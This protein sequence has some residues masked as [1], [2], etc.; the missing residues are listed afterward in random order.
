MGF[1]SFFLG[2]VKS[3]VLGAFSLILLIGLSLPAQES[4]QKNG[5]ANEKLSRQRP[6]EL[7]G[8]VVQAQAGEP[9]QT[10]KGEELQPMEIE[11]KELSPS[12]PSTAQGQQTPTFETPAPSGTS[13]LAD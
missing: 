7:S 2:A 6:T 1:G 3:K 8:M 12:R 4:V 10:P 5:E 13:P 11:P 9:R